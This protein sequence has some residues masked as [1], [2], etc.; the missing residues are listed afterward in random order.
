MFAIL[1]DVWRW[2][3]ASGHL[4]KIRRYLRNDWAVQ[5]S[6]TG[7]AHFSASAIHDFSNRYNYHWHVRSATIAGFFLHLTV[8]LQPSNLPLVAVATPPP[9]NMDPANSIRSG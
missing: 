6:T 8:A 2:D 5:C 7:D 4:S 1:S 9:L 3:A